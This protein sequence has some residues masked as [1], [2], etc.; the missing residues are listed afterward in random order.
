MDDLTDLAR[1]EKHD[2]EQQ[3][4]PAR[5]KYSEL[6]RADKNKLHNELVRLGLLD[7]RGCVTVFGEA[8]LRGEQ[9][10]MG[11]VIGSNIETGRVQLEFRLKPVAIQQLVDTSKLEVGLF[12]TFFNVDVV[13]KATVYIYDTDLYSAE[14]LLSSF[15]DES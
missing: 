13:G 9:Q 3:Q 1:Q 7:E 14:T 15:A 11:E 8:V 12:S 5:R 10:S 2:M 4:K 6:P